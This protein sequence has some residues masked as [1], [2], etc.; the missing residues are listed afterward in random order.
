[1]DFL[2][3]VISIAILISGA[4]MVVRSSNALALKLNLSHL[5]VGAFLVAIGTSLPEMG[6]A[7]QANYSGKAQMTMAILIGSSILNMTIIFGSIFLFAK[8]FKM[9]GELFKH[10]AL[11][12]FASLLLFILIIIDAKISYF[13]ALILLM[14]VGSYILFL[15][16]DT[17]KAHD[18]FS[19]AIMHHELSL[20]KA[21]VMLVVGLGL[22]I[23]GSIFTI[24]SV[25]NIAQHFNLDEWYS[26]VIIIAFATT[27]PELILTLLAVYKDQIQIAIANIIGSTISNLTLILALATL[28]SPIHFDATKHIFDLVVM[29][30]AALM[31]IGVILTQSYNRYISLSL[32]LIFALFF[33]SY[34]V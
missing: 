31:M 4:D 19:K 2:L 5:L 16:K 15:F 8:S 23:V 28:V 26:G 7:I 3:F 13:D 32:F 33:Q 24:D 1:M 22:W 11:W 18:E 10:D 21:S 12:L 20:P 17:H 14:L 6:V 34:L 30:F 29:L 9:G 27:L 25:G